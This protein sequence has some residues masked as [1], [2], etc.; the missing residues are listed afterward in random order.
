MQTLKKKI[1][2]N[3]MFKKDEKFSKVGGGGGGGLQVLEY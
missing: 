1:R 2:Q 3:G